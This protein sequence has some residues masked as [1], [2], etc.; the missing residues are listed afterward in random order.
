M[1][2][3]GSTLRAAGQPF[4]PPDG[5]SAASVGPWHVERI[6]APAATMPSPQAARSA[7]KDGTLLDELLLANC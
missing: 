5:T 4:P 7:P 6:G 1:V 2:I 3:T